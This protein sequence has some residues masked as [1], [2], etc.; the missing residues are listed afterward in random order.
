MR[1]DRIV[2]MFVTS[3]PS[4]L[5]TGMLYLSATLGVE[6]ERNRGAT[7]LR[8]RRPCAGRR[9][10]VD[11]AI[12]VAPIRGLR[13]AAHVGDQALNRSRPRIR[14]RAQRGP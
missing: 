11:E 1:I 6:L 3:F 14:T 2:P 13:E 10:A 12:L 9:E 7:Q 5:E 8:S 4:E